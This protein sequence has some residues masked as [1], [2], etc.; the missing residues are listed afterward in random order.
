VLKHTHPKKVIAAILAGFIVANAL[1]DLWDASRFYSGGFQYVSPAHFVVVA[2]LSFVVLASMIL[3]GRDLS[4]VREFLWPN[5]AI[6]PYRAPFVGRLRPA[7]SHHLALDDEIWLDVGG[8]R[9]P[10][11]VGAQVL[12]RD[13]PCLKARPDAVVADVRHHPAEPDVLVLRNLSSTIWEAVLP[14]GTVRHIA[15]AQTVRLEDGTRLDF[16]ALNGAILVLSPEAQPEAPE[17]TEW[18]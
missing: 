3:K 16:G 11:S 14:D 17:E 12:G 5:S 15:P 4:P 6:P 2:V 1:H 13:I 9:V 8:N 10:L 7:A 18:C